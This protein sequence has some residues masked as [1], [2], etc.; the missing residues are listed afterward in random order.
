MWISTRAWSEYQ[1]SIAAQQSWVA[2]ARRLLEARDQEIRRLEELSTRRLFELDETRARIS[3]AEIGAATAKA[4]Y[5]ILV[6]TYNVLRG[7]R[8]ALLVKIA[9]VQFDTA[10]IGS[11]PMVF[12]PGMDFTDIG[13]RAAM[14][15]T[16]P[17]LATNLDAS[18]RA[19]ENEPADGL[20][21]GIVDPFRSLDLP[22]VPEN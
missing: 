16:T 4:Y 6:A 21:P 9:G 22:T 3:Q 11:T 8:D 19:S 20:V 10:R 13:D 1:K 17:P 14:A 18:P 12:P 7:E 15:P 5:D 2:E